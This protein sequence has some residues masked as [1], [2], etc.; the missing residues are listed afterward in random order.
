MQ[1]QESKDKV[2]QWFNEA[3]SVYAFIHWEERFRLVPQ[4]EVINGGLDLKTG[5]IC[6]KLKHVSESEAA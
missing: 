1:S 4:L 3:A 2:K 6:M 5:T